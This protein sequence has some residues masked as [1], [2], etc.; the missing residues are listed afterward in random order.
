MTRRKIE[1]F[2]EVSTFP[3]VHEFAFEELETGFKLKGKW[4]EEHFQNNRPIVLELGCGKGEYTVGLAK[5]YP[6]KNFIG[7]DIK[8]NRIWRGA[9]TVEEDGMVNAAFLRTRIDF[10]DHCFAPGEV[11]EIWITFPDPQPQKSRIRKRLTS[12]VFLRRYM[13]ILHPSGAVRLKT[14]S[15]ELWEYSLEVLSEH[16]HPISCSTDNLYGETGAAFTDAASIETYYESKFRKQGF[17]IC[18]VEFSLR[19]QRE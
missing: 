15:R 16:K 18:Y 10:I 2:A 4:K 12:P 11:S 19:D 9:K 7:V 13:K 3:H 14:D 5:K 1:R 8:G 17:S 6:D